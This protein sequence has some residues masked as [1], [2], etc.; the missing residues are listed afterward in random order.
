MACHIWHARST[1]NVRLLLSHHFLLILNSS[2][3]RTSHPVSHRTGQYL[4]SIWLLE[5]GCRRCILQYVLSEAIAP[6][7]S[8]GR[9]DRSSAIATLFE[10]NVAVG[11]MVIAGIKLE[12]GPRGWDGSATLDTA[13]KACG[14]ANE[15][16][17]VRRDR[18]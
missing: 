13:L 18:N 5:D 16:S 9:A 2:L 8:I 11:R 12:F 10:T 15:G 6:F 1:S 7:A 14:E 4:L 17:I 3:I